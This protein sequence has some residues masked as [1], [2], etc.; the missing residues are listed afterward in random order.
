MAQLYVIRFLGYHGSIS[1]LVMR[2]FR[3]R[4]PQCVSL[5]SKWLSVLKTRTVDLLY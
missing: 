5:V 3:S 4:F 1:A 2:N